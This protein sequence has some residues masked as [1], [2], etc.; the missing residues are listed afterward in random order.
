MLLEQGIRTTDGEADRHTDNAIVEGM[1]KIVQQA[2]CALG[3]HAIDDEGV[4]AMLT[5]E[6]TGWATQLI[7]ERQLTDLQ[8]ELGI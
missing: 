1:Q 4:A 8:K 7:R 2:C 3:I 6:A 5:S